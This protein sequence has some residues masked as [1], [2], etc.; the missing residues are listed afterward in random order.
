M[1]NVDRDKWTGVSS[2]FLLLLVC[3]LGAVTWYFLGHPEQDFEKWKRVAGTVGSWGVSIAGFF[4]YKAAVK[5]TS[6]AAMLAS[7]GVRLTILPL[8]VVVGL[9]VPPFHSLTLMVTDQDSS[10][11]LSGVTVMIDDAGLPRPRLSDANG[12]LTAGSLVA[13]SHR[14]RLAKMGYQSS[15]WST[16]FSDVLPWASVNRVALARAKGSAHLDSTPAGAAVYL[17]EDDRKPQGTTPCDLEMNA[18]PHKVMFRKAGLEPTGWEPIVV[19]AGGA[20]TFARPLFAPPPKSSAIDHRRYGLTVAS[21]PDDAEI[22]V[23]GR[24]SGRTP[25]EVQVTR[26]SHLIEVKKPG[27]PDMRDRVSVPA[28]SIAT[29]ELKKG[30]RP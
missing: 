6:I 8:T 3:D 4:G 26:G 28:R 11:P 27:Y 25:L 17:D 21:D 30:G 14:L 20:F 10:Q 15:D 22:F 29:F 1:G 16:G 5:E 24:F 23:D 12:M 13:S 7:P 19:P 18:G 9:F 2:I